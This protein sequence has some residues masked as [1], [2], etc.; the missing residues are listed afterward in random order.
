MAKK[1]SVCGYDWATKILVL[2]GALNWGLIGIFN[3]NLVSAIFDS[4]APV[5]SRIVYILV[6][7]S[8][9]YEAW[10]LSK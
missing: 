2:V 9:L 8:A 10:K 1:G 5:I 6:G 3:W 4:W 7:L